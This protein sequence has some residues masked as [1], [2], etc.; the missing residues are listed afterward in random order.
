MAIGSHLPG[1]GD[2]VSPGIFGKQS[3][4]VVLRPM[5]SVEASE[6]YSGTPSQLS[7]GG[8]VGASAADFSDL[9]REYAESLAAG[10]D[11]FMAHD[12]L[13][14]MRG[15]VFVLGL[16]VAMGVIGLSGLMLWHWLR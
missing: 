3:A 4:N 14:A 1:Q 12:S 16:Y 5:Q 13:G 15:F 8:F 10:R 6:G 2:G 11:H 7:S 9:E